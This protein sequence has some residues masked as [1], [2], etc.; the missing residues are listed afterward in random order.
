MSTRGNI[1]VI[2]K[3]VTFWLYHHHDAYPEGVG[4]DLL[5]KFRNSFLRG[6]FVYAQDIVNRLIK[7]PKDDEYEITTGMH[8]DIEYLYEIDCDNKTIKCFE[9]NFKVDGDNEIGNEVNLEA[10]YNKMNK[11]EG[12]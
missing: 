12:E 3:D 10:I 2:S 11:H 8:G 9:I 5:K 6:D 7:D 1:K 4:M